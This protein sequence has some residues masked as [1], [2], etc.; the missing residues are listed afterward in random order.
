[1]GFS[2]DANSATYGGRDILELLTG[3]DLFISYVPCDFKA[4]TAYI[5]SDQVDL[6][7]TVLSS[8]GG[9]HVDN[10]TGSSLDENVSTLPEGRTLSAR[11][12]LA[13]IIP[14]LTFKP[15]LR[16]GL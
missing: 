9:R 3:E 8:L 7:V 4:A 5:S 1:L 15:N 10:L 13:Q 14:F 16:V 6:G 12:Y 11:D 2:R